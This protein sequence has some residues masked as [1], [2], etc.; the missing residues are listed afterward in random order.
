MPESWFFPA[1]FIQNQKWLHCLD[2]T[3]RNKWLQYPPKYHICASIS[4]GKPDSFSVVTCT[5]RFRVNQGQGSVHAEMRE[6]DSMKFQRPHVFHSNSQRTR[7]AGLGPLASQP[8][9]DSESMCSEQFPGEEISHVCLKKDSVHTCVQ[10]QES[11][12]RH[13]GSLSCPG[14]ESDHLLLCYKATGT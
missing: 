9:N 11:D 12:R 14:P 13:P 7:A 8:L 1:G 10:T 4:E 6:Q 5:Y 3:N 2:L